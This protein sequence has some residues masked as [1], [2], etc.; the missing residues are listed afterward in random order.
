VSL[1]HVLLFPNIFSDISVSTADWME[2]SR[3]LIWAH[4]TL[5]PRVLAPRFCALKH[6]QCKVW[7]FRDRIPYLRTIFNLKPGFS[8]VFQ[9]FM[10]WI[11]KTTDMLDL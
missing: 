1:C 6:S 7:C 11:W 10:T 5:E 2:S 9:W 8:Y 3:I 4:S